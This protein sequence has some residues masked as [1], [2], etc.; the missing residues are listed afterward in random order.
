MC[1]R[2]CMGRAFGS[3]SNMI[4]SPAIC[5]VIISASLHLG[6]WEGYSA[7]KASVAALSPKIRRDVPM[8]IRHEECSKTCCRWGMHSLSQGLITSLWAGPEKV[9][10]PSRL[11]NFLPSML[12]LYVTKAGPCR[13]RACSRSASIGG[14]ERLASRDEV[15]RG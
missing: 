6:L 8:Y 7:K 3:H 9:P 11:R 15:R 5:S 12:E 14:H 2:R 10:G 1:L 4:H 13:P